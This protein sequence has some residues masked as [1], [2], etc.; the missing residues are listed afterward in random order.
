MRNTRRR[1]SAV[2]VLGVIAALT[3]SSCSPRTNAD[4]HGEGTSSA[5]EGQTVKIGGSWTGDQAEQL[6]NA[7]KPFSEATGISV[8][9]SGSATYDADIREQI[10]TGAA[11]DL[12][13]IHDPVTLARLLSDEV[14]SALP[15]DAAKGV[16]DG[17]IPQYQAPGMVNGV[18]Y[19]VPIAMTLQ[20]VVYYSPRQFAEW[21]IDVPHTWAELV[22]ATQEIADQTGSPA[23]C[24]GFA[25]PDEAASGVAWI[26]DALL[27]LQGP[28][29]FDRWIFGQSS[30][31]DAPIRDT[32]D[33][34]GSLLRSS[35][36]VDAEQSDAPP[37][38]TT[39][40]EDVA[41][42][43]ASGQCPLTRG[44]SD[45]RNHIMAAAEML[46]RPVE[47]SPDG[48]LYG[49]NLPGK[50]QDQRASVVTSV[51]AV[52]FNSNAATAL[53]QEYLASADFAEAIVTSG[54]FISARSSVSAS[55]APTS[56]N[57]Q[58]ITL[59]QDDTAIIRLNPGQQLA[60]RGVIEPLRL[61]LVAWV[62][63]APTESVLRDIDRATPAD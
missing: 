48:D 33:D 22:V 43:V 55:D 1:Q 52:G 51:A 34:V 10:A 27:R 49:F 12:A 40:R 19:A 9:Y 32:F 13:L 46:S 16:T 28:E 59:L 38:S 24:E 56:L 3:L 45:F 23:W 47:Y 5:L 42:Q 14:V 44:D 18:L 53:V 41:T 6:R 2:I 61:G 21:G 25:A 11:P 4:E 31:S 35:E 20:S 15:R 60:D 17:W 54:G 57:S 8:I 58:A 39:T 30:F 63:G 62:D 50:T 26:E 7:L 36:D 37:I 29:E